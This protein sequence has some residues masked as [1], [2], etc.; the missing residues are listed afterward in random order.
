[1]EKVKS[2]LVHIDKI[3]SGS[4]GYF[5]AL[6]LFFSVHFLYTELAPFESYSSY[7]VVP[8]QKVYQSDE[9]IRFK[10]I[11]SQLDPLNVEWDD[12]LFCEAK[13][14][15]GFISFPPVTISKFR[16]WIPENPEVIW[17]YTG[18]RPNYST[19]CYMRG[20]MTISLKYG[21]Q[22]SKTVS[23][24]VFRYNYIK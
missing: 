20:T 21:I 22:K 9:P 17:T 5:I 8:I 23:T 2:Q 4:I 7:D 19:F 10:S 24:P 16:G 12:I 13:D 6:A 15:L 11:Y 14:N 18:G 1:M 3:K